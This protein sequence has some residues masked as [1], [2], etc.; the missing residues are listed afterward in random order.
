MRRLPS[1]LFYMITA[2]LQDKICTAFFTANQFAWS[3]LYFFFGIKEQRGY[4]KTKLSEIFSGLYTITFFTKLPSI[5]NVSSPL[6]RYSFATPP[7][8]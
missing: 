1:A 3:N 4:S 8:L 7:F 5:S 2:S 6:L